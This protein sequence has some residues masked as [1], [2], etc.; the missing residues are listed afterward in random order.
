M[1]R[2][3]LRGALSG[4]LCCSPG[5]MMSFSH[6]G[7]STGVLLWQLVFIWWAPGASYGAL[8]AAPVSLASGRSPVD[9]AVAF[10][11][12]VAGYIVAIM[13]STASIQEML[14]AWAW[15]GLSIRGAVGALIV[16][17]GVLP[18]HRVKPWLVVLLTSVAGGLCALGFDVRPSGGTADEQSLVSMIHLT[19]AFMIWQ[20]VTAACLSLAA[21]GQLTGQSP[22]TGPVII[23]KESGHEEL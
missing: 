18:S 12:S 19:V 8:V 5:L 14:P 1:A 3:A 13:M 20:S 17:F 16:A 7:A 10:V 11:A 22:K 9:A 23:A 6:L 4:L 2:F 15:L 21:A